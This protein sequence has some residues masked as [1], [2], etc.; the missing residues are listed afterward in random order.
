MNIYPYGANEEIDFGDEDDSAPVGLYALT[1]VSAVVAAST[2]KP[3]FATRRPGTWKKDTAARSQ[4]RL[5]YGV[6]LAVSALGA[7]RLHS[8]GALS[9]PWGDGEGY[10]G[11]AKKIG[12]LEKK[13]A[14]LEARL[15][16]KQGRRRTKAVARIERKLG[17]VIAKLNALQG[18]AGSQGIPGYPGTQDPGF[19]PLP[20]YDPGLDAG[21]DA[22]GGLPSWALPAALGGGIL[23]VVAAS[24]L[25]GGRA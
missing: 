20:V 3:A 9:M 14:K 13:R 10:G 18:Q 2:L 15:A 25:R 6:A 5:I 21:L 24:M 17:K 16:K 4:A 22:E 8:E 1:A 23:L 12:R 7:Y 11:V 19:A